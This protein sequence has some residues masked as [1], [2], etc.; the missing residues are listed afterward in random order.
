MSPDDRR[1]G[2][3]L[4]RPLPIWLT[5][6]S[7][8]TAAFVGEQGKALALSGSSLPIEILRES[9]RSTLRIPI[10]IQQERRVRRR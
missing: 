2:E 7:A 3:P 6:N 5:A 4:Q 8:G 9:R 10:E 1:P